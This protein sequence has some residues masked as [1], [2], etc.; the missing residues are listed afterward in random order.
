MD[1]GAMFQGLKKMVLPWV[2]FIS[3]TV[4]T[5]QLFAQDLAHFFLGQNEFSNTNVYSVKKQPNGPLYVATNYGLFVYKNGSFQAIEWAS[6]HIGSS[7]FS[8]Q[9]DSKN[10][11]Y[12]V[13]LSG[14]IFRLENNKLELHAT[15]PEEY[16]SARG[17]NFAF[18]DMDNIIVRSN[19][20][21]S[22]TN[23]QWKKLKSDEVIILNFNTYK[24]D[25]ILLPS[26]S[27]V[28]VT[29]KSQV[30]EGLTATFDMNENKFFNRNYPI[31]T[32]DHIF[33]IGFEGIL[34]D[35]NLGTRSDLKIGRCHM[36]RQT[37]E[38]GAWILS[39]STGAYYLQFEG[40]EITLS[41]KYFEDY[42]ISSV[43]Q[44]EDGTVYLGTFG[45]GIIVIPGQRVNVYSTQV[46]Q[47]N[48]LTILNPPNYSVKN[49]PDREVVHSLNSDKRIL[50]SARMVFDAK[51]VNF[52]QGSGYSSLFLQ[53]VSHSN[54]K[55]H[56]GAIKDFVLASNETAIC[57]SSYGIFKTGPGLNH[58]KW[59]R[60]GTGDNWW[61]LKESLFRC[62]A[63]DYLE[64]TQELM[65]A[66]KNGLFLID[67]SGKEKEIKLDGKSLT[68]FDLVA[69]D[70]KFICGTHEHGVLFIK[71]GK[72][73][74]QITSKNGLRD[75]FIEQLL[76]HNDKLYISSKTGFQI[77]DLNSNNWNSL[78]RYSRI[79][80]GEV[81]TFLI[82]DDILWL[83]S[84]GK[85]ISIPLNELQESAK[86]DFELGHL[87]L[88]GKPFKIGEEFETSYQN[89]HLKV[90][91]NFQGI[92]YEE[93][94]RI[95]YRMNGGDWKQLRA[96]A[97]EIEFEALSPG[98]YNLEIRANYLGKYAHQ[99]SI[100]FTIAPPFWQTWWFFALIIVATILSVVFLYRRRARKQQL[101]QRLITEG[102]ESELKAL[103]SQM[104]PHFI[105]NSLN[106]IQDLVMRA[107]TR[108]T[109]DYIV[110]FSKLVRNTLNYS[111]LEFITIDKEIEFLEVYLSL[112]KL[113]FQDDFEY[114]ISYNG[115]GDLELP[116]LLIQ[117]FLE[118]ALVHGLIHKKGL[119]KLELKFTV[120]DHLECR[121]ID[122]G[123]GRKRA[124]EILD[125]QRGDHKS[126]AT[127]AIEQRLRLLNEQL[128][129]QEASYEV[130]DLEENGIAQG[131]EVIVRLP[132]RIEA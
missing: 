83:A 51:G 79:I 127:E 112:E 46:R 117:P 4:C 28:S 125:R 104:N 111:S 113:R 33:S 65:Y 13:N 103:R 34:Y 74:R 123:I 29:G 30:Y 52:E 124:K 49:A 109:Y 35:Y 128:G 56:V 32:S 130:L 108:K 60:N 10:K 55:G 8:L 115:Q 99:K 89:N 5:P 15:V 9:L 107:D 92:L 80:K 105:F 82:E 81:S 1:I 3:F 77:L 37:E 118:N 126:F 14:Q 91:L 38:Y 67:S 122:N 50:A 78:G 90:G 17:I 6:D 97:S 63:V 42:F 23:R 84:K 11:V 12:C 72:I 24:P 22:Y 2:C 21:L 73:V 16:V 36:T 58:L 93:D 71:D 19:A 85:M 44:A 119:K 102:L 54:R 45:Y 40:D 41:P 66:S 25:R 116:S 87:I 100:Q 47:I 62:G 101:K 114:S 96:T 132:L 106:S 59:I 70:S 98:T 39:Q 76:Y 75:N 20:I 94:T 31:Q 69:T 64:N 110:L 121:I 86:F 43:D 18:D 26:Q 131:T 61:R 68:S 129:I 57:A 7:V 48:H 95:E 88:G 27:S 120:K 53:D